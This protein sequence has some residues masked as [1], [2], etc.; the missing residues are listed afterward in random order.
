MMVETQE[1]FIPYS[2]FEDH[3]KV[4]FIRM[5]RTKNNASQNGPRD[6][7][8]VVGYEDKHYTLTWDESYKY[9]AGTVATVKGYIV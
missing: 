2:D 4:D 1:I 7:V 5:E 8:M 9:F 6:D 3:H